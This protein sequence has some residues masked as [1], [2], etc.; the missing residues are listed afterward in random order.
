MSSVIERHDER[1]RTDRMRFALYIGFFAGLIWG[2]V[3]IIEFAM[4]FTEVV[5]GFLLEPYYKHSYLIKGEG[6]MLG[7]FSFIL[8]SLFASIL[9]MLLLSRF[10]GPW[11]G[12]GYGLA[13]WCL[14]YLLIGPVSGMMKPVPQLDV[15]SFVADL[16][17]FILWGVFIGYSIS[18]EF[19]DEQK[20]EAG[21]PA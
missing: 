12:F 14:L 6:I 9:Y 16:C 7:W 18:F 17:L 19:T 10:S 1:F 15:N 4:R 20:R 11:P 3:K 8:F 21:D 2:G 13:W 5:P